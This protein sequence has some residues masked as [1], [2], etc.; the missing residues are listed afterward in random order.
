FVDSPFNSFCLTVRSHRGDILRIKQN[1]FG[2][3]VV[4]RERRG[5][6]GMH[7]S[8]GIGFCRS[9]QELTVSSQHCNENCQ[10]NPFHFTLNWLPRPH[11]AAKPPVGHPC[12]LPI[13][14]RHAR[15][16]SSPWEP[17]INRNATFSE[18]AQT[19]YPSQP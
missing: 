4:V 13:E 5:C 14:R 8:W 16:N 3:L 1:S 6:R 9:G 12:F 2:F 17:S 19:R 11:P 7:P 15:L 18:C 10:T